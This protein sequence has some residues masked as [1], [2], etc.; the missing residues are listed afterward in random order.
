MTNDATPKKRF[1]VLKNKK[2]SCGSNAVN[3]WTNG[4]TKSKK[5]REKN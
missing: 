5:L 4:K 3:D 2:K 1:F